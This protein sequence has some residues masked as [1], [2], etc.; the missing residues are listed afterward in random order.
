MI[1]MLENI[2][3]QENYY[4]SLVVKNNN[5]L[6]QINENEAHLKELLNAKELTQFEYEEAKKELDIKKEELS[7]LGM[8]LNH[9]HT[10]LELLQ[11]DIQ[12]AQLSHDKLLQQIED[13]KAYQVALQ[14]FF[15]AEPY[16]IEFLKKMKKVKRNDKGEIISVFSLYDV[17][18]QSR[19][20]KK[21][22]IEHTLNPKRR[23][24][25]GGGADIEVGGKHPEVPEDFEL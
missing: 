24:P 2:K 5:L 17:Y 9:L 23:L 10:E 16:Y 19:E 12:I 14:N 21:N 3:K 20:R 6:S 11:K 22:Q 15:D 7:N 4:N 25:S 13:D 18:L 1:K 8:Q